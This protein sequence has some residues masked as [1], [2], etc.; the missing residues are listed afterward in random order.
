MTRKD[1]VATA[2]ILN[3]NIE[4]MHPA[5]FAEIVSKFADY[6]AMDNDRFDYEK[7]TEA[8]YAWDYIH[9]R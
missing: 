7:F 3:D 5:A 2:K 1:Y 8:C 4:H 9:L 6:M